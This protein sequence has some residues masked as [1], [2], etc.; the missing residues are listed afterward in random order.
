[1]IR[2]ARNGYGNPEEIL[3]M[4][5]DIVVAMLMYEKFRG[6]YE[7]AYSYLNKPPKK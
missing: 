1:V 5:V 7:K 3:E 4:R 6:D 2:L